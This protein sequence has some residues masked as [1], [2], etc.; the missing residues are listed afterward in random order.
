MATVTEI[1]DRVSRK[2]GTMATGNERADA[3]AALNSVYQ[4]AVLQSE[5]YANETT[6]T[7]TASSDSY[8]VSAIA[9]D[10]LLIQNIVHNAG[11]YYKNLLQKP[12]GWLKARRNGSNPGGYPRIYSMLGTNKIAFYPNPNV[13]DTVDVTYIQVPPTLVESGPSAGEE[14]T[15]TA[16]PAVFHDDVLMAG[17]IVHMLEE[18]QRSGDADRWAQRYQAG[19][20]ALSEYANTFGGSDQAIQDHVN[21]FEYNVAN[22]FRS[23]Y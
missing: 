15:P 4:R 6:Y 11:S 22:D 1:L 8:A 20:Y 14:S 12:I 23:R 16:I 10:I 9:T 17:T 19:L 2:T 18:D 21:T 13:N 3:L 7:F 5:C